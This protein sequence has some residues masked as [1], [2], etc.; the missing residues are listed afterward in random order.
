MVVREEEVFENSPKKT[1][2]DVR[3]EIVPEIRI[4]SRIL[5]QPETKDK[6]REVNKRIRLEDEKMKGRAFVMS[7]VS[8][9]S[10]SPF[11]DGR[12]SFIDNIDTRPLAPFNRNIFM[13]VQRDD[14]VTCEQSRVKRKSQQHLDYGTASPLQHR[15]RRQ[16]DVEPFLGISI[17]QSGSETA[18]MESRVSWG[19]WFRKL[20]CC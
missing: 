8:T 19:K 5:Q 11:R 15:I 6:L 13:N 12:D 18:T 1:R 2:A 7:P 20:L 10:C 14:S 16:A 4:A 3:H 17:N 9:P